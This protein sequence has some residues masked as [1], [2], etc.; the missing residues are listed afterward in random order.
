MGIFHIWYTFLE[1]IMYSFYLTTMPPP[2]KKTSK[3][4]ANFWWRH[5][6]S[7]PPGSTLNEHSATVGYEDYWDLVVARPRL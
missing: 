7:I 2:K 4:T 6:L 1:N 3:S 5:F